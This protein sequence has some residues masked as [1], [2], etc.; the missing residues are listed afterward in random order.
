M[1][2]K[3]A[4][5]VFIIPFNHKVFPGTA[6]TV[7]NRSTDSS[8]TETIRQYVENLQADGGTASYSAL[9]EVY[10]LAGGQKT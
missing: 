6:M 4:R 9:M 7:D 8:S 10:L 5:Q 2:W 1:P 3:M